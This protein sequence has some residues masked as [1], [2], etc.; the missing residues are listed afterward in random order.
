MKRNAKITLLSL[1]SLVLVAGLGALSSCS[2]QLPDSLIANEISE[3]LSFD[4]VYVGSQEIRF[5]GNSTDSFADFIAGPSRGDFHTYE[6]TLKDH[7][8]L[9]YICYFKKSAVDT[10]KSSFDISS[11]YP[12]QFS[13]DEN[14][15]DGKY[16]AATL[17]SPLGK[18]QY[19]WAVSSS[20]Q[21]APVSFGDYEAVYAI[22]VSD[23]DV[24]KDTS[25]GEDV[26]HHLLSFY[27]KVLTGWEG[28][29]LSSSSSLD[30]YRLHENGTFLMSENPSFLTLGSLHL[31]MDNDAR[32]DYKNTGMDFNSNGELER[33]IGRTDSAGT[34][35]DYL[36]NKA[37]DFW[38]FN[39]NYGTPYGDMVADYLLDSYLRDDNW[40]IG[41]FESSKILSLILAKSQKK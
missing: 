13:E 1:S 6:M 40:T 18:S 29:L 25:L 20:E 11:L 24:T 37:T 19:R 36:H 12:G 4:N 26:S 17:T 22:G 10:I 41:R 14:V 23:L 7:D 9:T 5:A 39:L 27:R 16:Y 28:S 21:K 38:S 15:I 31:V 8:E 2:S 33:Y 35:Y 34:Y 32:A 3:S 30:D